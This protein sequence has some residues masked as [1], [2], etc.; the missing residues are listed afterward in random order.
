MYTYYEKCINLFSN[1]KDILII[2]FWPIMS[3]LKF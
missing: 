2:K 3:L 1:E